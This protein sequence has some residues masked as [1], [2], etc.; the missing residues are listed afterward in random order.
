M[1]WTFQRVSNYDPNG[2]EICRGQVPQ[3][4]LQLEQL[5]TKIC[6]HINLLGK[7][8]LKGNNPQVDNLKECFLYYLTRPL[9]NI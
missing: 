7:V 1:I 3:L 8:P 9:S 4:P 5:I 6:L 2:C